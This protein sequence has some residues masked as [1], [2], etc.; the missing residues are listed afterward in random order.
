MVNSLL[1]QALLPFLLRPVIFLSPLPPSLPPSL[2]M[3]ML[4]QATSVLPAI[5]AR[6]M[7]MGCRSEKD[8][9]YGWVGGCS[10]VGG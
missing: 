4:K 7:A 2:T 3:L 1:G 8:C 10:W 9:I 6:A 5:R